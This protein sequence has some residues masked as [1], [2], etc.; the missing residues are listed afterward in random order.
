[1]V[2]KNDSKD[3]SVWLERGKALIKLGKY[4]AAIESYDRAIDSVPSNIRGQ[5]LIAQAWIGKGDILL[6][7]AKNREALVA[8]DTAID[9][10]PDLSEAWQGKGEA[11]KAL[12]QAYNASTSLYVASRLG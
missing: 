11:Q 2:L 1:V 3:A 12:G 10:S 9:L 6:V 7:Q 8:Y 5:N 4:D